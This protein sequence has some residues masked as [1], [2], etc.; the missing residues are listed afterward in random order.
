M[1]QANSVYLGNRIFD[2]RMKKGYSLEDLAQKLGV[3]KTA[4]L[5]W[6]K[7]TVNLDNASSK[8]VR[9]L[10]DALGTS[11]A[12]LKGMT[13]DPRP[14][15]STDAV[16]TAYANRYMQKLLRDRMG[17][18]VVDVMAAASGMNIEYTSEGDILIT[19]R[20][21]SVYQTTQK[22]LDACIQSITD[23]ATFQLERV[24]EKTSCKSNSNRPDFDI[25]VNRKTEHELEL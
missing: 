18:Y 5:K 12:Y 7:G 25:I 19:H 20:D 3:N 1:A 4:V 23:F 9:A 8:N 22:E 15:A 10:A 17:S 11:V 6:E 21:G 13:D 24:G 16:I 14:E 2:L